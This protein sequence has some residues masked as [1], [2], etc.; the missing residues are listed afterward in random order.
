MKARLAGMAM[1]GAAV[2][3]LVGCASLGGPVIRTPTAEVVG[4]VV[5]SLTFQGARL[6]FDVEISNPNAVGVRLAGFDYD[7]EVEGARVLGGRIDH[8]VALAARGRSI[9]PV[10][11]ELAFADLIALVQGLADR[12]ESPYTMTVG[13]SFRLPVLGTVR[14][15]VARSGT[16]PVVRPPQLSVTGLRLHRL[17]LQGASLVLELEVRSPNGFAV[18][19]DSL[20]YSLTVAGERWAA[21]TMRR[22]VPLL[23]RRA[24]RLELP[25][26]LS[27]TAVG[28]SARN[29]LAGR[30]PLAYALEAEISLRTSLPLL[31]RATIPVEL[32]GEIGLAR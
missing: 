21:G 16:L 22:T 6:R 19:L 1:G 13:L 10:P 15:A 24:A 28:Q 26:D 7:L 18:W 11:V 31:P 2:V 3:V 20:E 25:V 30:D 29:I 32:S 27:F 8:D 9:V 14:V 4:V 17:T 12:D 5:E 23:N